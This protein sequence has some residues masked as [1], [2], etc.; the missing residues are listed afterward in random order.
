MKEVVEF[1]THCKFQPQVNSEKNRG[2]K[3]KYLATSAQ[4]SPSHKSNNENFTFRPQTTEYKA[5]SKTKQYLDRNAFSRLSSTST[6]CQLSTRFASQVTLPSDALFQHKK[7]T[8]PTA[9]THLV[10][11][12]MRAESLQKL[13]KIPSTLNFSPKENAL[14]TSDRANND[15]IFE[16]LESIKASPLH[17]AHTRGNTFENEFETKENLN[18]KENEQITCATKNNLHKENQEFLERQ[19]AFESTRR[20]R[21]SKITQRIAASHNPQI[22]AE[23]KKILRKKF[24]GSVNFEKRSQYFETQKKLKLESL[25]KSHSPTFHPEISEYARSLSKEKVQEVR[26]NSL[27]KT[28]LSAKNIRT[29]KNMKEC[30][31]LIFHPEINTNFVTE[32]R[33][34]LQKNLTDYVQD[35]RSKD[36]LSKNFKEFVDQRRQIQETIECTHQP[37]INEFPYYLAK[38]KELFEPQLKNKVHLIDDKYAGIQKRTRTAGTKIS[39]RAETIAEK[40]FESENDR[41]MD[42]SQEKV[43]SSKRTLIAKSGGKCGDHTLTLT[44]ED[45]FSGSYRTIGDDEDARSRN[46]VEEVVTK[47]DLDRLQISEVLSPHIVKSDR[48]LSEIEHSPLKPFNEEGCML[49]PRLLEKDA[50]FFSFPASPTHGLD[51]GRKPPLPSG[52]RKK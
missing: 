26:M 36:Q 6:A 50:S 11:S 16:K 12:T 8:S 23:S 9:S 37:Q 7:S 29:Q 44:S 4:K 41:T 27:R 42:G 45:L 15:E 25:K 38:Q 47:S 49:S 3:S 21:I 52:W 18:Y 1:E 51:S 43:E 39:A 13:S 22:E 24:G 34:G 10:I 20:D 35:L 48:K 40:L 30:S 46:I 5:K 14:L 32:S 31:E 17:C 33:L 28:E 2:I 19:E